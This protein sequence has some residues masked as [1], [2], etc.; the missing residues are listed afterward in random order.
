MNP[1]QI[2]KTHETLIEL[3]EGISYFTRRVGNY[4]ESLGGIQAIFPRLKSRLE[5]DIEICEMCIKRLESRYYKLLKK[6]LK[7][8]TI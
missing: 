8:E 7:D 4:S 5:H 2:I 3:V 1:K 6:L